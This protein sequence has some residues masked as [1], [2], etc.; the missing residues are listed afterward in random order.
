MQLYVSHSLLVNLDG[1]LK[2]L[3]H[4][5]GRRGGLHDVF[6]G[7]DDALGKVRGVGDDPLCPGGM[8]DE[9]STHAQHKNL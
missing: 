5:R 4:V 6:G 7:V 1:F 3:H 2:I 9:Q 8:R